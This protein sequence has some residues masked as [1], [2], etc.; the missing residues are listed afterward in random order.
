MDLRSSHQTG[1]LTHCRVDGGPASQTVDQHQPSSGSTSP[2]SWVILE[3]LAPD[4]ETFLVSL[5]SVCLVR[6]F[7]YVSHLS[8]LT[9]C[10][11]LAAVM[12]WPNVVLMLVQRRRRRLII[13]LLQHC[14][15]I[16]CLLE[17]SSGCKS[18]YA[19]FRSWT[20]KYSPSWWEGHGAMVRA[21]RSVD[22][23]ACRAVSS[24]V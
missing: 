19:K 23:A 20:P 3:A 21:W 13:K 8:H 5:S 22:V 7:T 16:W 6:I 15:N 9:T 2:V 1:E 11:N 12:D 18:E 14:F 17:M 4:V 10:H 24:P